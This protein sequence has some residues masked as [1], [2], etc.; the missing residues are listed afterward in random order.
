MYN[1][2]DLLA[3]TFLLRAV[4]AHMDALAGTGKGKRSSV[5]SLV[6]LL[7]T[8]CFALPPSLNVSSCHRYL[9]T[10]ILGV[11]ITTDVMYTEENH[12][13]EFLYELNVENVSV[14]TW[15]WL[16]DPVRF[17]FVGPLFPRLPC[18]MVSALESTLYMLPAQL[19]SLVALVSDEV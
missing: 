4:L 15:S 11:F 6:N 10:L 5:A 17:L 13:P 19:L 2:T 18:V 7:T 14:L 12:Y 1:W 8:G 9:L 3:R 16:Q